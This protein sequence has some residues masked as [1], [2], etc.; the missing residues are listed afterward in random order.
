[1]QVL[2]TPQIDKKRYQSIIQKAK[3]I[4]HEDE[5]ADHRELEIDYSHKLSGLK[6]KGTTESEI[7]FC[8]Y[9]KEN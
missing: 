9:N 7:S 1:M 2:K 5:F 6:P 4:I 3:K 8:K